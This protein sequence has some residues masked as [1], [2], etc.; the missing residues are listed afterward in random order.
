MGRSN[1]GER[2]CAASDATTQKQQR[3]NREG[4]S[5]AEG[6]AQ[7]GELK[8]AMHAAQAVVAL[9]VNPRSAGQEAGEAR[10]GHP[11]TDSHSHA[12]REGRWKVAAPAS[13]GRAASGARLAIGGEWGRSGG[14]HPGAPRKQHK[15]T[16]PAANDNANMRQRTRAAARRVITLSFTRW[17]ATSWTMGERRHQGRL[18]AGRHGEARRAGD[19]IAREESSIDG[20]K[21]RTGKRRLSGR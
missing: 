16:M 2:R 12:H 4:T 19:G 10:R 1:S 18:A 11:V 14:G 20:S 8:G 3:P 13:G 6:R 7:A 5:S 17:T 15:Q 21:R 9:G